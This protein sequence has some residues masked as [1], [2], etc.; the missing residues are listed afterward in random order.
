MPEVPFDV[1]IIGA[2]VVGVAIARELSRYRVR[3][4][5]VEAASDVGTGTSKA[6]TAIWHTGFDAKPKTL[7]ASLV[8]R[9]YKLLEEFAAESGIPV[10]RTG[11]LMI[12]WTEQEL[13][14]LDDVAH[15]ARQNGYARVRPVRTDELY[16]REPN[17]APGALGA[18]EI[19][20]EGIICTFTT[21]LALATQAVTNGTVLM[22]DSPVRSVK[23]AEDGCHILRTP[24]GNIRSQYAVNA[25]GL[26]SDTIDRMFGHETFTIT[27][28]RGELIVFDKL[29]RSLVSNVL[30]P[31]PTKMG[32][33]VLVAPT[34]FGNV[35]LGPTAE[36]VED[37]SA[38]E[39]TRTGLST[40]WRKGQPLIPALL[41]EE[42]TAVYSGLRAA[43]EHRD[44]QIATYPRERYVCVGGIRSTGL[45]SSMA[46]GEYVRQ[47]LAEAGLI[48]EPKEEFQTIRMPN[49]G[50][51]FLRP[52]QDGEAIRR[53]P[54]YGCIVCHCERVTRGEILAACKSAIPARSIDG[55]RRRTRATMGRCQG[56]YCTAQVV[57]LLAQT[58]GR[59]GASILGMGKR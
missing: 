21:P 52:Y 12:A 9:G 32:K 7:E 50:E 24:R 45:S 57:D 1:A 47:L 23:R 6:N 43:T 33:G 37:R 8:R 58:T 35:V 20:D 3:V 53:N 41:Q 27:P 10:E 36:D 39:S 16:R 55:L 14:V 30:L 28:R 40:L 31:V 5:L 44:Y 18:I 13:Q 59:S 22:L 19:P 11:A 34:V 46:I 15:T 56:F 38:T 42:V 25:A 49:I 54:D 51:S 26:Y 17:L 29:S 2:G 4:A 48:L